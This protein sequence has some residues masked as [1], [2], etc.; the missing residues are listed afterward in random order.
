MDK[1]RIEVR[2]KLRQF[3]CTVH[4]LISL[5]EC[6]LI[7]INIIC[8]LIYFTCNTTTQCL[9]KISVLCIWNWCT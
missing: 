1:E 2:I 8:L 7:T 6:L 3:E 5:R 9:I 4:V